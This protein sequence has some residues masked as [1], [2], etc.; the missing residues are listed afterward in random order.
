[1]YIVEDAR[2]VFMQCPHNHDD[3][4]V[5]YDDIATDCPN[6]D[7]ALQSEPDKCLMRLLGGLIPGDSE[8]EEL[9]ARIIIACSLS[10]L[11]RKIISSHTGIG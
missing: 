11:Y 10:K 4:S 9:S 6:V 7:S 8:A 1:M 5:L 3:M 2:H